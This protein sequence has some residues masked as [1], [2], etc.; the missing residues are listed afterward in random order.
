MF[1]DLVGGDPGRCQTAGRRTPVG[2]E[3]VRIAYR[4]TALNF[5]I[6]LGVAVLP[7]QESDIMD[8]VKSSDIALYQ[9]KENGRD[10]VVVDS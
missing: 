3:K 9:A 10:Q 7:E 5:T 4:G 1:V 6:S 2:S 8:V